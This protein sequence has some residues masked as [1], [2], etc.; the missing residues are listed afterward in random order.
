MMPIPV[1]VYAKRLG[2]NNVDHLGEWHGYEVYEPTEMTIGGLT[3]YPIF[4]LTKDRTIRFSE[5]PEESLA[6]YGYFFA[7]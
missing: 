1:L 6:I 3:G 5:I 4:I 7:E 2:Y